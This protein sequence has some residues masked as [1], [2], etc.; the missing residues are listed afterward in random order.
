LE[1]PISSYGALESKPLSESTKAST[2]EEQKSS[3][4]KTELWFFHSGLGIFRAHNRP[5]VFI[6]FL[7]SVCAVS[8][9]VKHEE[10][11]ATTTTKLY[12]TNIKT[13]CAH[14]SARTFVAI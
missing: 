11:P 9:C 8:R 7:F 5:K 12:H 1:I 2:P 14:Y 3:K 4:L 13:F 6:L 10:G